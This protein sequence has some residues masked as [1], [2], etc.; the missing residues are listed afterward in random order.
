MNTIWTVVLTAC[1]VVAIGLAAFVTGC[2]PIKSAAEASYEAEQLACIHDNAIKSN[3]DACRN[4][5]KARWAADAAP[6]VAIT[7]VSITSLDGGVE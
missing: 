3:A 4:A 7:V 6:D 2:N 1:I 5:V